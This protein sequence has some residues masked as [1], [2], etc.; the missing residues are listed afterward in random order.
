MRTEQVLGPFGTSLKEM[1]GIGH[2][3]FL[4]TRS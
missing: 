1:E 4:N 2:R 3:P